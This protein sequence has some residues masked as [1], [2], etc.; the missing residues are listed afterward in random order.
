M[1][2]FIFKDG[3]YSSY[4]MNISE[5]YIDLAETYLIKQKNNLKALESMKNAADY[6]ILY[7]DTLFRIPH[8]SPLV[9]KIDSVGL[10]LV[11]SFKGNQTWNLLKKF[12]KEE[13]DCVRDTPEFIEI[14]E[15]LKQ[16]AKKKRDLTITL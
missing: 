4:S 13:Y 15:N 10:L 3:D 14:C 6:G 7:D 11:K 8:T 12:D 16:H 2:F 1:Y 5:I 9:N